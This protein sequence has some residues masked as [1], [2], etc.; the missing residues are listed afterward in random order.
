MSEASPIVE[1]TIAAA[2][3]KLDLDGHLPYG[4]DPWSYQELAVHITGELETV[5][6]FEGG[7]Q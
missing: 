1:M 5:D 2:L 6:A 7:A 3:A 4:R